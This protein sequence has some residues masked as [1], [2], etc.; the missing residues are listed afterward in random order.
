MSYN[1][2]TSDILKQLNISGQLPPQGVGH[3]M[4]T[5][6]DRHYEMV[7][8]KIVTHRKPVDQL[9]VYVLP[10]TSKARGG[11]PRLYVDCKC[12]EQV[13]AGRYHQHVK[14]RFHQTMA[15]PL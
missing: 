12:G 10:K 7:N 5:S 6:Y 1:A 9:I 2:W 4:V 15:A 14:G 3:T 11:V 13:P 8:G